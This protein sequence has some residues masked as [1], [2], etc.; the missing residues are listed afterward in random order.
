M[1]STFQK[2]PTSF[3]YNI[4]NPGAPVQRDETIQDKSRAH[5][6][7]EQMARPSQH[8]QQ[9]VSHPSNDDDNPLPLP[10]PRDHQAIGV[11]LNE[12]NDD[13]LPNEQNS[14]VGFAQ[15]DGNIVPVG[16]NDLKDQQNNLPLPMSFKSEAEETRKNEKGTENVGEEP[17]KPEVLNQGS[18]VL[19]K[20]NEKSSSNGPKLAPIQPQ[21]SDKATHSDNRGHLES[22]QEVDELQN[23]RDKVNGIL[24]GAH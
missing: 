19:R 22:P 17:P 13:R 4:I 2:S 3:D 11:T 15:R 7:N 8:Q 14:D 21:K 10:A 18:A 1:F 24:G 12:N 6:V 5:S 23:L 20:P 16:P 9:Q